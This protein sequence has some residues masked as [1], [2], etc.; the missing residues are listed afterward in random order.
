M[1]RETTDVFD[2][3]FPPASYG[4]TIEEVEVTIAQVVE[5]VFRDDDGILRSCVHGRTMK[6]MRAEDVK[7]RP[8]GL[9]TF[10]ENSSIPRRV[11][12]TWVN[13]ENAGQASGT[14]LEAL[15]AKAC[16]TDDPRVHEPARRTVDALVTLWENAAATMHP[17]GGGGSGWLPKPYAGIHDVAEMHECSADQYCEVTLGLHSY[18]LTMAS[19]REKKMIEEIIVSFADWWYDHDYCGVYF[20]QAIW[21]KRL[22]GHSMA[23]GFFLYLNALAQ[24]WSPSRKFQHGFDIWM[25]LKDKLYPPEPVWVCMNGVALECLERLIVLRPELDN[26]WR[27]AAAH[28]AQLVATSVE[29][30]TALNKKYEVN[31][32]AAHYLVIADRLMPHNGYDLLARRCLEACTRRENFYHVRRGCRVADL[33]KRESGD[34]FLD[35]FH[36]ELHVHWL[37]GYWKS[38]QR[39]L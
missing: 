22:D 3:D 2:G 39:T 17:N 14:Y 36:C 26:E 34:D 18:Y 7:N 13:Y 20:G 21:W 4:R 23:T 12:T 28:Q 38:C 6:P 8:Q 24:S 30:P 27:T 1:N 35:V 11:K 5:R 31:G 32:F 16:M 15:C 9:G 29:K 19:E 33:D 37:A 10:A 25:G